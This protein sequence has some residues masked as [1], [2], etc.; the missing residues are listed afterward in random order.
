MASLSLPSGKAQSLELPF[1]ALTWSSGPC[2]GAKGKPQGCRL[3]P[4]SLTQ[5][6]LCW[7]YWARTLRGVMEEA[8]SQWSAG[9]RGP[10]A[11]QSLQPSGSSQGSI[12]AWNSCC[13]LRSWGGTDSQPASS[14]ELQSLGQEQGLPTECPFSF[15]P[16]CLTPDGFRSLFALVKSGWPGVELDQVRRECSRAL[17]LVLRAG[18]GD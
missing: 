13:V 14:T 9:T 4:A 5:G 15:L 16:Q 12:S 2:L 17:G 3:L 1:P 6:Q 7:S 11:S 8:L 18:V 10:V